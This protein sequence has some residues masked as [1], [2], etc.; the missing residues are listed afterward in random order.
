MLLD[1]VVLVD[2]YFIG[3]RANIVLSKVELAIKPNG[4]LT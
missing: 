2:P 1:D 4:T 3:S